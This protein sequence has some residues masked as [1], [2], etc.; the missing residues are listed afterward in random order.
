MIE[1]RFHGRGGQGTVIASRLLATALYSEDKHVQSFAYYGAERRGAPVESYVR[2]DS[3][4]IRLRC[5]IYEPDVIVVLDP[6]LVA[7]S[8]MT[9]GLNPEGWI[10]INS[11]SP[12]EDFAFAD[13]FNVATVDANRIAVRHGLGSRTAPIVNTAIIGA[14]A[15]CTG[16]VSLSSV[17]N[18]VEEIVPAN[19]GGNRAAVEEAYR[20][21]TLAPA[22]SKAEERP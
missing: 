14:L 5:L 7:H 20:A 16:V 9:R 21:T 12:P 15:R 1:L 4:P 17:T 13:G 19:P 2:A 11:K 22:S 18:A 10:V 3:E 8:D 6:T